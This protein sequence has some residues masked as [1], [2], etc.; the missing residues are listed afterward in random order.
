MTD[1]EARSVRLLPF[2]GTHGSFQRR[3]MRFKAYARVHKFLQALLPEPGDPNLPATDTAA[4][5]TGYGCGCCSVVDAGKE[6]E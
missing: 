5:D 2:D 3:W 6:T 4:L 1:S